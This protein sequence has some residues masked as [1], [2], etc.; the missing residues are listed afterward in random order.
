VGTFEVQSKAGSNSKPFS[1]KLGHRT[2]R[3][4]RY[5]AT[6]VATDQAGNRSRPKRL[7]FGIARR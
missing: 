1:G 6:I 3:P 5:R 2:L 7:N 4:G